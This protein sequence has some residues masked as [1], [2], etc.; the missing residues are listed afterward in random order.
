M[1][2]FQNHALLEYNTFGLDVRT[3]Y[4]FEF[5]SEDEL[6][7]VLQHKLIRENPLLVIGQGSNL[8]FLNDFDG[9]VLH[10]AI[11]GIHVLEETEDG[12]VLEVGSGVVWDDLVAHCVQQGWSGIENLSLIPGETGA[13]AIQNIGAYGVEIKDVVQKVKTVRIA[14]TTR[15]VFELADCRY[16]YRESVFKKDLKGQHIV[17]SV[18]IRL[19]KNSL[20][21]LTYNHLEKEV[22][23]NGGLNLPNIR[24]T[25]IEIRESKLPDPKVLGNAGSFFMNPIVPREKYHAL[26]QQYPEMPHYYVSEQ[27]EKI[28]A[29]WLIEQCGWKGRTIG[30]VGVHAK[31][32]LVLINCGGAKGKEI[33]DL[34]FQ[35]QESVAMK[36]GIK[37]IPEVNFIG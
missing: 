27:E 23:K 20:F 3:N 13:A 9:V 18:V 34:A 10:S 14:D 21:N 8:L 37:L 16:A 25:I 7:A 6:I 30:N 24:N 4:F 12:V 33:A 26:Q 28:P 36:F 22:L 15:E 35:I 1:H 32:A 2:F 17:T 29:G 11:R 19:S 5:N 31:Q